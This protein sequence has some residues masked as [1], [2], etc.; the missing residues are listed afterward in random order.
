LIENVNYHITSVKKLGEVNLPDPEFGD[1]KL[2][3]M[4]FENNGEWVSLPE[5]FK[6]WEGIVQSSHQKYSF[7]GRCKYAW[8]TI[9]MQLQIAE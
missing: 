8:T 1:F 7:T 5:G 2:S 3:V 4:P 6:R 9:M